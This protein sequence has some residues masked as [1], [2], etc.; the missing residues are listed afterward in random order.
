MTPGMAILPTA[1]TGRRRWVFRRRLLV[2]AVAAVTGV[3]LAIAATFLPIDPAPYLAVAGSTRVLDSEGELLHACLRAD[4][5]WCLPVTLGEVHPL[6]IAATLA[7]EDKRFRRHGGVDFLSAARAAAQM[8]G[9]GRIVSGASTISMQVVKLQD[10]RSRSFAGKAIQAI[11]AI[12]LERQTT[13]DALLEAY[14]NR[15]PYGMNLVG[16][17]AGARRFFGKGARHLSL[18]EAALLAGMPRAPTWLN[19]LRHPERAMRR[20]ETVLQRMLEADMI[21][22]D[23]YRRAVDSPLG[24]AWHSLQGPAPHLAR[25]VTRGHEAGASIRTTLDSGIQ[26]EAVRQLRAGL[27]AIDGQADS[28]AIIVVD[29][30]ASRVLAYVGSPDVFA[31]PA[32][33]VDGCVAPRSPGSTLK[34]FTYAL[35]LQEGRLSPLEM[36]NDAPI[37]LGRWSPSNFDE[38]FRGD[39][40]AGEALRRSLNLP[41]IQLLGRI[42]TGRLYTFLREGG[43]TTLRHAAAHYGLGLTIG[44]CEARLDELAALYCALASDGEYR[45]LSFTISA[46][47]PPASRRI[48]TADAANL[49][50]GMLRQPLPGE[51]IDGLTVTR[52]LPPVAWKTG[53]SNGLRDAFAF[54]CNRHYVVGVWIGNASGAGHRQLI[55]AEAALPVAAALFRQLPARGG[56]PWPAEP[57]KSELEICTTSGLPAGRWCPHTRAAWLPGSISRSRICQK[58]RGSE[59][60]GDSAAR[61]TVPQPVM[62][63]AEPADGSV[64]ISSGSNRIH[65]RVSN[66][67]GARVHWFL[68]ASLLGSV[69]AREPLVWEAPHG[70]HLLLAVDDTGSRARSRVEIRE[71]R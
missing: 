37:D 50:L 40:E 61:S 15:A 31:S 35:A 16:C 33:H 64:F 3:A 71:G 27:A 21:S 58:H 5:Q 65:L 48:L 25:R 24:V 19:P 18:A 2:L 54:V 9:S 26:L 8:V 59:G 60:R 6:M 67:R 1:G 49:V 51:A 46:M 43:V 41:A 39:V 13:K 10:G 28:G 44:N 11:R 20:R 12:R 53:T 29:V 17:E 22:E 57:T 32:G 68:G 36:L 34:P 14:L 4:E 69:A 7:A 45:T 52:A 63:I 30:A 55:G 56:D 62:A 23:A 42:G 38:T 70:T 47:P 66:A